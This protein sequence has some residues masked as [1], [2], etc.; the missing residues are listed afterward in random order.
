M[1]KFGD[2]ETVT[3]GTRMEVGK[4]YLVETNDRESGIPYTPLIYWGELAAGK[5]FTD[6]EDPVQRKIT[7]PEG[8]RIRVAPPKGGRRSRRSRRSTRQSRRRR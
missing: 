2:S 3:R 5:Y 7:V 4:R 8:A 1:P 6:P